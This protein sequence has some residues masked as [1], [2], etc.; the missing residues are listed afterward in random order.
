MNPNEKF[1]DLFYALDM[2]EKA[3]EMACETGEKYDYFIE[4]EICITNDCAACEHNLQIYGNYNELDGGFKCNGVCIINW[5]KVDEED[6]WNLYISKQSY[7]CER[8]INSPYNKYRH[9]YHHED[10]LEKTK[11]VL[12]RIRECKKR[13]EILFRKFEL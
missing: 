6:R 3:W 7:A 1:K 11:L 12:Q 4:R 10:Q 5:G 2:C 13:Y 8:A 9:P